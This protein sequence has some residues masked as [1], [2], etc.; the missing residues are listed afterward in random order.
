VDAAEAYQSLFE[1]GPYAHQTGL[2]QASRDGAFPL[3]LRAPCGTGKTEAA[4]APWLAQFLDGQ[5]SLPPRL[6]YVLPTQALCNQIG[7]R[8]A[9][10]AG[11]TRE[12]LVVDAPVSGSSSASSTAPLLMMPC[13]SRT[14]R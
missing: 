2:F 3:V 10:A 13:C 12:R 14:S 5:F 9:R 7:R 1:F 11:R 4:V 8:L 6:I